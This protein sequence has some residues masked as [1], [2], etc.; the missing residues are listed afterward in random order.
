[1]CIRDRDISILPFIRQ[2]RIA[3]VE[4][5]DSQYK[6]KRIK[7]IIINFSNSDLFKDV[8]KKYDVW[9]ENTKPVFFS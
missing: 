5:F 4:W 9:E 7:N 1:M 8:M 6:I 3:D 2:F